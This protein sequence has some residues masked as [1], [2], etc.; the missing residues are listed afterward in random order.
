[1]NEYTVS[2]G[3]SRTETNWV[4]KTVTWDALTRRLKAV[5]RT[6][7]SVADYKAMSRPQRGK[8]KDTGG[9]VGGAIDGGRRK[10][11]SITSRSLVTLDID[12]GQAD[13]PEII[14]DVLY[15]TAWALYSTHSHTPEAPRFRLVVPLSREVTPDEYIPIA[16]RLAAQ[17]DIDIFDSSTYEPCRLMYWPSCPRDGEFVYRQG[18]VADPLD[19]DKVLGSYAD[20]RN[21]AEWPVDRRTLRLLQSNGAKQEDPTTKPGVIGAFCRIYS[22]TE[23]ISTFLQDIY[24][25]TSSD[26]RYTFIGGT[27]AAGDRKSVV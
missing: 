22:I 17:I 2:V 12:Y 5:K 7:E 10:G 16:R 26:D 3:R 24:A 21:V 27:T 4:K 25:P 18:D 6:P 9:F 14:A 15:D 1:M 23:A 13:T 11:D 8:V 20:W 19:A